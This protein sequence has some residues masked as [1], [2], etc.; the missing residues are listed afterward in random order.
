MATSLARQNFHVD[1]E[2]SI[3]K[4]INTVLTASYSFLEMSTHFSRDDV[5]L[6]NVS[7]FFG[8][9][10]SEFREQADKLTEYQNMRGGRVTLSAIGASSSSEADGRKATALEAM[11]KAL[12]ISRTC[13]DSFIKLHDVSDRHNDPQMS[14]FIEDAF[15]NKYVSLIQELACH[16]TNLTRVGPGLGEYMFDKETL[17][18]S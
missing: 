7:K 1:S 16:I 17:E 13:S 12:Q 14:D 15:L 10:S 4:Q 3:N 5:A 18:S 9:L 6:S 8:K 11:Q 2:A